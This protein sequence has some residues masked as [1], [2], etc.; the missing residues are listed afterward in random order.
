MYILK[1][2]KKGTPPPSIDTRVALGA[3]LAVSQ[4]SSQHQNRMNRKM[5][6]PVNGITK[7]EKKSAVNGT[8]KRKTEGSSDSE[9]DSRSRL[10][11]KLSSK[12]TDALD[13]P[14]KK[15]KPPEM[16]QHKAVVDTPQSPAVSSAKASKS[17]ETP[18]SPASPTPMQ[19]YDISS[20]SNQLGSHVFPP[21]TIPPPSDP[22]VPTLS[23]PATGPK[24]ST[25][26]PT[27][28]EIRA[29]AELDDTDESEEKRLKKQRKME[30]KERKKMKLKREG[31]M[32]S[33]GP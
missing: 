7:I 13:S 11:T 27:L 33:P 28:F 25:D 6:I 16:V 8:G 32:V 4:S 31:K 3:K 29:A 19:S 15:K 24:L 12:K 17:K 23:P 30:K 2:D 10:I 1:D 20:P 21:E 26:L 14:K 9:D 5:G 18:T 22:L